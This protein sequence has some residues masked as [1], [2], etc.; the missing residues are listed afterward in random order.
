MIVMA[1]AYSDIENHML[2]SVRPITG[3]MIQVGLKLL[4][5]N[6]FFDSQFVFVVTGR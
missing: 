2:T 4:N 3:S 1:Q 6:D 5:I